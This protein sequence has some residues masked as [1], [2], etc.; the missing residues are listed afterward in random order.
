[1]RAGEQKVVRQYI[2]YREEHRKAREKTATTTPSVLTT[3]NITLKDGRIVPLDF[4]Q[5]ERTVQSACA[6]LDDVEAAQ[7]LYDT[8]RGLFEGVSLTDV[9]KALIM[10][11]RTLIEKE[12]NYSYVAAR[13]LLNDLNNEA[14]H[15]L[16]YKTDIETPQLA[17]RYA[18]LLP[19]YIHRG[20]ELEL[21]DEACAAHNYPVAF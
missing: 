17:T 13:L 5:L 20:V 8:E 6:G 18:E 14:L 10:A 21:L 15:F 11:A 16:G 4:K 2:L 9:N 19:T 12:P 7:I 1:M 3:L